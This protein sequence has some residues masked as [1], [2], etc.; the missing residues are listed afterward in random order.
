MR[1]PRSWFLPKDESVLTLLNDQWRTVIGSIEVV[2][3]WAASGLPL[4]EATS[5]LTSALDAEREQQ[6]ALH[7]AVRAAFSTPL[8]AEDIYELGERISRLHRQLFRLLREAS[9]ASTPIPPGLVDVIATVAEASNRL[10][11]ALIELPE[12]AAADAAD[13][14]ADLLEDADLLYRNGVR[15]AEHSDPWAQISERE[16]YRRAELVVDAMLAIAHRAW[17]SV[18][19]VS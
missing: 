19:K 18:S 9:T 10:N 4:S 17:Y 14:A 8:D 6:R 15:S 13:E 5:A 3:R 11:A 16:M 2:S 7:R 1:M 12:T